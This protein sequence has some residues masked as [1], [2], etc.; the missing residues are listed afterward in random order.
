[1]SSTSK[2]LKYSLLAINTIVCISGLVMLIAGAVTLSNIN[3]QKLSRTIGG[4]SLPAGSVIC[5][6][7]GIF[8]ILL[9]A[10][11]VYSTMKDRYGLLNVYSGLM[12]LIFLIQFIT[13]AVALGVKNSSSF[14]SYAE[15]VFAHELNINS[16]H[17]IER[18]FYQTF[19]QCCGW[20]GIRDYM[21]PNNTVQAVDSCCKAKGC[22]TS[23]VTQLFE[24]PCNSKLI[25]ASRRII[26]VAGSILLVFAF[27]NLT[28]IILSVIL[29][30]QIRAGYQYT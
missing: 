21:L 26:D 29:A 4:Y 12:S 18:D 1:M 19:F 2:Y 3:G 22:D 25:G 28:S 10:L 11:G 15:K 27:F 24:S 17:E 6:I 7:F 9:G 20:N 30:R 13:G 5:I 8:I 14:D 16:T 23:E